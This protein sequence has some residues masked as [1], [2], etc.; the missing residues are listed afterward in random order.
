[1]RPIDV[2]KASDSASTADDNTSA[3]NCRY[4]VSSGPKHWSMHAYGEAIDVNT[5]ENPYVFGGRARPDRGAAY[6]DRSNVRPGMAVEGGVLVRAFTRA[7]WGWGGRWPGSPD[8]QHFS[9]TGS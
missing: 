4:A 3:F 6:V 2:Y 1:M 9:T 8:Y 5:V 7:G